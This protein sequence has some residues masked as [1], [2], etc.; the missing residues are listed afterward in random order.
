MAKPEQ[1]NKETEQK[2]ILLNLIMWSMQTIHAIDEVERVGWAYKNKTKYL[3]KQIVETILKEHGNTLSTLWDVQETT[4]PE[5]TKHLE[6][7]TKLMSQ[8]GYW[9]LPELIQIMK[10]VKDEYDSIR[11][12]SS[13]N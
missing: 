2:V 13:G 10:Q 3:C 11:E 8:Q 4:M 7:F 1:I 5:I 9:M 6:E 12:I